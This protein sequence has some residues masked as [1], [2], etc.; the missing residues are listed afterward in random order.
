MR[1]LNIGCGSRY[2]PAWTNLDIAPRGPGVLAHDAS[3]GLPFADATF[4]VVYHSHVLEHVRRPEA[5]PFLRDCRR[6]LKPGGVLRVAVPDL[7]QICRLYLD[8]LDKALAGS[9]ASASD[10]EWLTL[11]MYDQAVREQSGGGMLAYLR[12]DPL[13]NEDFVLQRIGEEGREI[14]RHVRSR[15][16][17]PARRGRRALVKEFVTLKWLPRLGREALQGVHRKL[18]ALLLGQ[19]GLKCLAVSRFRRAGEVHQWMYDRFALA[20]LLRAAG[21]KDPLRQSAT[22]SRVPGWAGFHLDAL[23]DGTVVKPDSLFMEAI[24]AES[25]G[26]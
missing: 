2:H 4:D 13:P 7:E 24:K 6:V 10:H 3:R 23:A 11:E 5:L 18:V 26:T 25:Y 19:E 16:G 9:E 20:R 17:P 1:Y 8:R 22:A 14:V 21:Y 15:P 12:Q